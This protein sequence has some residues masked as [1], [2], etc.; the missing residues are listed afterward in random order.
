MRKHWRMPALVLAAA[1]IAAGCRE[2]RGVPGSDLQDGNPDAQAPG[3]SPD[4]GQ[5]SAAID[6]APHRPMEADTAPTER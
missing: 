3:W 5:A 4:M 1:V 2:G 6:T